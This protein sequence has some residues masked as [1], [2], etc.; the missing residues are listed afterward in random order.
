MLD[1]SH[2]YITM[3]TSIALFDLNTDQLSEEQQV[4]LNRV[5]SK[6]IGIQQKVLAAKEA[7]KVYVDEPQLDKAIALIKQNFESE[8]AFEQALLANQLSEP[9]LR[10]ALRSELSSEAVLAYISKD[11]PEVTEQQA[12]AFYQRHPDK[13]LQVERRA[14]HHIL[15]T[16]NEQFEENKPKQ[17]RARI[18]SLANK[19]TSANFEKLAER[20]SECPTAVNGGYL[21]LVSRQQLLAE[22]DEVLFNMPSESFSQPIYTGMGYHLLW[23]KQHYPEHRVSFDDAKAKIKQSLYEHA[24]KQQQRVWLSRACKGE[25]LN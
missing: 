8:A 6:T 25:N 22:L 13:F 5:V 17:A 11:I 4:E 21:G 7:E 3:K 2:A 10:E 15:L 12:L 18:Q 14:A 24:Q 20:H 19:V 16:I 9:G 1:S 23:C